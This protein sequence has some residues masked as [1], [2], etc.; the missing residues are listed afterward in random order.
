[1]N[2]TLTAEQRKEQINIFLRDLISFVEQ[3]QNDAEINV[4]CLTKLEELHKYANNQLPQSSVIDN[5]VSKIAIYLCNAFQSTLK[6]QLSSYWKCWAQIINNR[7][8]KDVHIRTRTNEY[9]SH[10]QEIDAMSQELHDQHPENN[11][12]ALYATFYMHILTVEKI[13]YALQGDLQKYSTDITNF[14]IEHMF[15]FKNKINR[16]EVKSK[17]VTQGRAIRD[18]LAHKKFKICDQNGQKHIVFENK[19]HGYDFH[20][21]LTVDAFLSY[22]RGSNM[23]YKIMYIMQSLML[24]YSLLRESLDSS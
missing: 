8:Q 20:E 12:V 22:V 11:N 1:M 14:D 18:A 15:S 6:P 24:L 7:T 23:L 9:I 13:E 2:S 17:Y 21:Q 19:D 5:Y 10:I 3:L 16:N 4:D